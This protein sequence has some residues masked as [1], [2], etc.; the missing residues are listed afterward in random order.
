MNKA[1]KQKM[2]IT[3]TINML[4]RQID[5]LD[6]QKK[7]F[8]DR[9]KNA[10]LKGDNQLYRLARTML[11]SIMNASHRLEVMLMNIEFAVMQRDFVEHNRAFVSGMKQLGKGLI[12]TASMTDVTKTMTILEKAMAKVGAS[13]EGLD[14]MTENNE[15]VFESAVGGD[16]P[17]AEI[18]ALV[19][20]EALS[21]ESDIDA[22][23]DKLLGE[24]SSGRYAVPV[25]ETAAP[26]AP[27]ARPSAPAA[28]PA[29]QAASAPA[30]PQAPAPVPQAGPDGGNRTAAA[31]Y[32]ADGH[33]WRG[34]Y[35]HGGQGRN[36]NGGQGGKKESFD[37]IGL[38][39]RP[40]RLSDYMGQPK[41]VAALSDPIKK[42]LLTDKPL[43]H[44]LLCGSYGQGKT[45]LAKI[46]ANEMG[47]NFIELTA[48]VKYRDM[49]RT[50]RQLKPGDIIFVDEVHKLSSDVIETLLYPAMED[51]EVHFTEGNGMRTK[52]VSE[53]ISP[54]TFVGATTESGKLLKPFYSKF[55]IKVT[56]TE[57]APEIITGIVKNSFSK[58]GM[59]IDSR[60]AEDIA[61]RSR[62]LPRTANDYVK[63]I[64]SSAI[65]RAAEKRGITG[66]GALSSREAIANLGITIEPKD[67][68]AYFDSLGIDKL[69]LK[70]EDRQLLRV[71]IT[72]FGGG[73]TGQENLAKA[74]NMAENRINEEYEPYLVKL[75]FINV[76]PQGRYATD[77][78]Y[79][80]LG[81][82]KKKRGKAAD[83]ADAAGTP[84]GTD[85]TAAAA[86]TVAAD[87]AAVTSDN[88]PTGNSGTAAG[89]AD[90]AGDTAG[91]TGAAA[92]ENGVP[93]ASDAYGASG[94]AAGDFAPGAA[95]E[96][97]ESADDGEDGADAAD[98]LPVI[99]C[100]AGPF[101]KS[102]AERFDALFSGQAQPTDR[103]LDELFPDIGKEYE[104]SAVNRCVLRLPGGREVYCDSKL[105][106]R[107]I[108]YLFR[109]GYCTDCKS[110]SLELEYSSAS[111]AG[112]KYFPD[113]VLK[114]HDGRVAVVEMKNLSSLGYHLNIAKY[115]AL[116]KFCT[117]NGYLYAEVA[118]DE[119]A[120]RY[121]SAEIV[122]AR[123]VDEALAAAI[124]TALDEAGVFSAADWAQYKAAHPDVTDI[125]LQTVLLNEP[126]FKNIDR[127][128]G[129]NIVSAEEM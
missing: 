39:L 125:A 21:A 71:I 126:A 68:Y 117:E 98:D 92:Q 127:R 111:M 104:S 9:A 34:N 60:L 23:L 36:E 49:L 17:D 56:L 115:E 90:D 124:R 52:N 7:E 29:P 20:S 19:G 66:R 107:F 30:A 85:N 77:A 87:N 128:G 38:A 119:A 32:G 82:Q 81:L 40:Q 27:P 45:T 37:V 42:S 62:L 114:L 50:L 57:Y 74:L 102:A 61:H 106:R 69:G 4:K 46:I 101:R 79:E 13:M 89:F 1:F 73:P 31:G 83:N 112:K 53:K 122:A 35:G 96:A 63:G 16:I 80:Y 110:E 84:A 109:C 14:L 118:K 22:Q 25:G 51:F 88:V 64:A 48:S 105:E 72:M 54:F 5:R 99:E 120:G 65:V 75:G 78:A 94:G 8:L 10:R 44:V 76:R 67:V 3:R 113:F 108:A 70:D 91:Q 95:G 41:A 123:P 93:S 47:A 59:R 116:K 2:E 18:D 24:T 26:A 55:P 100:A 129:V 43:P 86:D 28:A 103:T 33:G 15:S 58:L 11:K 121:V 12:K 6:R 97:A